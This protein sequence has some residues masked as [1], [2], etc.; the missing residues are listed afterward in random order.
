MDDRGE[1]DGAARPPGPRHA[2]KPSPVPRNRPATP[3]SADPRHAPPALVTEGGLPRRSRATTARRTLVA[4]ISVAALLATG[5][6]WVAVNWF[7]DNTNTTDVIADLGNDPDAPPADDGATD[8]LLVGND[9]R[10]DAQG[11]PLPLEV[12]KALRTEATNGLNTDT[13]MVLRIPHDGGQAQAVS[14]PRDTYTAIPDLPDNKINSAYGLTRKRTA[15]ELYAEGGMRSAEV[16]KAADRAGRRALVRSVQT[17]TG[18]R[19]DH[20]AE[21][22]LYGFYLLTKSIGGVPVCLNNATVDKDSGAEFRAGRQ[23]VSGGD[24]L[25]YVRQRKNLPD[26]DLDR[27]VRQ[28]TFL[29]AAARKVLSAGTLTDPQRLSGLV[30]TVRKSVT[31]D[32]DLDILSFIQQAQSLLSGDVRFVT[33][34]VTDLNGRSADGQSIVT[35]DRSKVRAFIKN[36][37]RTSAGEPRSGDGGSREQGSEPN[38]AVPGNGTAPAALTGAM[39]RPPTPTPPVTVDGVRCVD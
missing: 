12:L 36:L 7:Q 21:I 30:N 10:T 39:S 31:L 22:T 11:E 6:A 2:A 13:I 18:M 5:I 33:I 19:V 37:V 4:L 38:R 1:R 16:E 27:I 32:D 8:I 34:P 25:A 9:T 20:Y 29:A 15:E 17:L 35:V 26:G 14:I 3:P 24:A 28:Q 23:T